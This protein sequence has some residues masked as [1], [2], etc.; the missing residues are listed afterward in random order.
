LTSTVSAAAVDAAV[1]PLERL[2]EAIGLLAHRAGL[3]PQPTRFPA[4]PRG[5]AD[6]RSDL[7]RWIASAADALDVEAEPEVLSYDAA[8]ARLASLAPAIVRL[9][10]GGAPRYLAVLRCGRRRAE[11]LTPGS[12]AA[13]V[14]AADVAAVLRREAEARHGPEVDRLLDEA[15]VRAGRARVRAELLRQRLGT[16]PIAAAWLLRR[17]PSAPVL[18]LAREGG[19]QRTF[20]LFVAVYVPKILAWLGAWWFLWRGALEGRPDWGWLL[21]WVLVLYTN[22]PFRLLEPWFGMKFSINAGWILK[23]RLLAGALRLEPEEIRHQ[24]T[25]QLLG[26]AIE[27]EAAE[28]LSLESGTLIVSHSVDLLLTVPILVWGAGGWPHGAALLAWAA[29]CVVALGRYYRQRRRWTEM[30]LAATHHLVEQMVGHSTRLAQEAP[31]SRHGHDDAALESY[32]GHARKMDRTAATLSAAV[33]GGWLVLSLLILTPE[34][35]AGGFSTAALAI[36][37]GGML[38]ALQSLEL[39]TLGLLGAADAAIAWEKVLP[40]FNAAARPKVRGVPELALGDTAGSGE[41]GSSPPLVEGCE[42]VFRYRDRGEAVLRKCD[43][44]IRRGERTL[45]EGPSG[46]GKSTLLSLILGLRAPDSGLLFLDGLDRP[47]LGDEGWRRR[48]AAAPQFHE[49][50]VFLHTFAFNLLMGRDWPPQPGDFEEAE[51]VCRELGLGDLL[52]RMPGGLLQMVGE[53]GW[54]L[55]HGERSRLYI[56]RALL[57]QADL[58]AFDESFAAL[59]PHNLDRALKTVLERAPTVLV[60]AHP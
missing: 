49:N 12:S 48:V 60:I 3:I 13:S 39:L 41:A 29:A 11:L 32:V 9:P 19:L 47:S 6:S 35:V 14:P 55:S 45:L 46:G 24:G 26:R 52:D 38:F 17:P 57:Q 37:V 4:T 59:D 36:A 5:L 42:L 51:K 15:G 8:G 18:E 10:G 22:L 33:P 34:V 50:H 44:A 31:G 53:T 23:R 25:G 20:V 2:G 27:S 30:R 28:E 58:L 43:V 16:R 1:W 54:Q 40:L 21:A 56:A 7:R